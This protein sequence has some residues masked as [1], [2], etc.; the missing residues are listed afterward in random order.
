MSSPDTFPFKHKEMTLCQT[1]RYMTIL[2]RM[3]HQCL[4][5]SPQRLHRLQS[6][7]YT[8]LHQLHRHHPLPPSR[9]ACRPIRGRCTMPFVTHLAPGAKAEA[10]AHVGTIPMALMAEDTVAHEPDAAIFAPRYC[11]S[12][13]KERCMDTKLSA[14]SMNVLAAHGSPAPVP[15]T[16][17]CRCLRMRD[18]SRPRKP[19]AARPIG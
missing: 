11:Y 9:T 10:A 7:R 5:R 3:A 6:H 2:T 4:H 14:K 1:H 12:S 13:L 8:Q 16:Q 17:L 19:V 18:W 15:Y